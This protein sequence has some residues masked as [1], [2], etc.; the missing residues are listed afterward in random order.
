MITREALA[1][2]P[3]GVEATPAADGRQIRA[4]EMDRGTTNTRDRTEMDIGTTDTRGRVEMATEEVDMK[5]E[6][7]AGNDKMG[8]AD[9]LSAGEMR[10]SSAT[11]R[12]GGT[13]EGTD[14]MSHEDDMTRGTAEM[15]REGGMSKEGLEETAATIRAVGMREGD[16]A[17]HQNH[18][19]NDRASTP[20]NSW[21]YC[22]GE[23]H[24]KRDCP[25]LKRAI[26]EGLVVL[27][28]RT[29][30]KWADDLGDV[31][32]FLS[33][34]ENVEARRIKTSK[35]MEPVRSQSIK[36]TFEGDIA[37]TPIRVAATKSARGSTSKK[38][39]TDNVMAEKDRQR[40]DGEEVILSP[41]KRGVKKFLMKS[42]LDEIDTVEPLRRALRQPMQCSILEYLAASKPAHDELQ[43]ITRKTRIPLS[44][45]PKAEASTVAVTGVTARADRMATVLLDGMEGVPPDKF[46]ILGSGAVETIINDGA[47]LD[48]VIDN[49]S[50]AVIIDEDL[51]V[52]VGLGLDRSY[53]FEIE[54]GDGRKQQITGVCHN[55]AIEV[56]GVR[57]TLPVFS[58]K[59]CSSD[60]L[61][62]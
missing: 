51:A 36:I 8:R 57:V 58:V 44:E 35:G 11:S 2:R 14:V 59:N 4:D 53:L 39:D 31:S 24:V 62:G 19:P 5:E 54:K 37:T 49:G 30:V 25:D 32:M 40:V 21:V 7:G 10:E 33:M 28:D 38:T 61:L 20:R 45:A 17:S 50:E 56:Q 60:L 55:A 16:M 1:M 47:V 12:G 13:T 29:Y 27:D 46:Y 6:I 15:I 26:D 18:I 42:S 23:D 22:R 3:I 41:R 34:K 43:M 52:Q 48:D 9:G